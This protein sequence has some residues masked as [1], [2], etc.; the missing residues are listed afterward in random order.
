MISMICVYLSSV[1]IYDISIFIHFSNISN[2]IVGYSI[3]Y[4]NKP[5]ISIPIIL[6]Q[7]IVTQKKKVNHH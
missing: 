7:P 2:D 1:G 6:L 5:I 3:S 4:A